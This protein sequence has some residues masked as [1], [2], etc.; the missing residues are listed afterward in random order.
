MPYAERRLRSARSHFER[1]PQVQQHPAASPRPP[2]KRRLAAS[3]HINVARSM[4]T[5]LYF[6]GCS[7]CRR[8]GPARAALSDT[9]NRSSCHSH[10]ASDSRSA[11]SCCPRRPVDAEESKTQWCIIEFLHSVKSQDTNTQTATPR[12]RRISLHRSCTFTSKRVDVKASF[13]SYMSS[14]VPRPRL[15]P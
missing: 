9:S 4:T 3:W 14:D 10:S 2:R 8:R 5:S 7:G 12:T 1:R 11:K 15:R 6:P 13:G